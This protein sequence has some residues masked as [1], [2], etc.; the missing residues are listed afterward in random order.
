M[1]NTAAS[2]LV[3]FDIDGTLMRGAGP[4]HKQALIDGISRVTGHATTLDGVDTAGKLDRDLIAGM[5]RAAGESERKIRVALK[6][7]MLACE[8]SYI[9]NCPTDLAPFLCRGVKQALEE[10]TRRG[11]VLGL[12]TGNLQEIGWRKVELAGIRRYF[13]V[14][15][16][17]ADGH[18]RARLAQIAAQ[19]ARR[20]GLIARHSLISLIG[21]HANDVTAARA[22]GFQAVAVATGVLPFEQLAEI[23][24]DIL[25][26][27][28]EELDFGRLLKNAQAAGR[29][30]K[31]KSNSADLAA[32]GESVL[33]E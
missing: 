18:T 20:A 21:D 26:R 4:H 8:Q 17:A 7:A 2:S 11:A 6:E 29:G 27:T 16:F 3:L 15:A 31:R 28:L 1:K 12:V 13:S 24:P 9:A 30:T 25:V 32:S 5:L 22:N 23:G 33:R 19:R 10:L 14:G